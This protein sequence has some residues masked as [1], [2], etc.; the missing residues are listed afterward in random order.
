ML[1]ELINTN[2]AGGKRMPQ[3]V[4]IRSIVLLQLNVDKPHSLLEPYET[5]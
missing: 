5:T 3:S 1:I 4:L 2:I